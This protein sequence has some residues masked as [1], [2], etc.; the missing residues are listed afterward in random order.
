[1]GKSSL[2]NALLQS[3]KMIVSDVPGT[4]RDSIDSLLR[5]KNTSFRLIDTAGLRKGKTGL[6]GIEYYS[7][8]RALESIE[9][10]NIIILMADA[11]TG[12]ERQDMKI[13]VHALE[14]KK[15]IILA[16]NKWDLVA[17]NGEAIRSLERDTTHKLRMYDFTLKITLSAVKGIRIFKA[18]DMVLELWEERAKRIPT[19]KLNT[20][21]QAAIKA[22]PPSRFNGRKVDIKYCTQIGEAPPVFAFIVNEPKGITA[23]YA[24]YLEKAIRFH[25]GFHG[26]PLTF[27]L[28]KRQRELRPSNNA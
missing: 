24:R 27:K 17:D 7:G 9:R 20:V 2:I 1:M 3:K 25:F 11:Q 16:F 22:I 4:T 13:L 5:Y 26:I 6:E 21:I 18:L 14:K 19:H 15:G 10:S 8:L 23:S 12:L 28:R